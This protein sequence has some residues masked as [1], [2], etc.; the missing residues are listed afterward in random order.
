MLSVQKADTLAI[1]LITIWCCQREPQFGN[2]LMSLNYV[3]YENS[4]PDSSNI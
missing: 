3:N 1:P 2:L 4:I